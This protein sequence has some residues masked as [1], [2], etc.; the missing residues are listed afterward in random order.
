MENDLYKTTYKETLAKAIFIDKFAKEELEEKLLNS[1]TKANPGKNAF[2]KLVKEAF[3]KTPDMDA[4]KE[5]LLIAILKDNP[6]KDLFVEI[7]NI[8]Y[9]EKFVNAELEKNLLKAILKDKADMDALIELFQDAL[10]A[11]PDMDVLKVKL[12]NA[13][14]EGRLVQDVLEEKLLDAI[15]KDNPDKDAFVEII[16]AKF[17]DELVKAITGYG[18]KKNEIVKVYKI[19]KKHDTEEDRLVIEKLLYEKPLIVPP[20]LNPAVL[21][22]EAHFN[23]SDDDPIMILGP[24]GVGKSLFLYLA[25]KLFKKRHQYDTT[26]PIIV[27]ANCAHFSSG[28][29]SYSLA[30]SELFGHVEGAYTGAHK[31]KVGLVEIANGGLLIL[32]EVGELPFEVQAMLLT[33]IETGEYRRLGNEEV[34]TA[35]V[36]VVAATNRESALRDDFRYRFFPFYIPPLLERKYDILYYFHEIFPEITKNLSKSEVLLLLTHHWPGNVREIERIGRLINRE[37][38]I[39][40][41]VL[42]NSRNDKSVPP[43]ERIFHLDPRDTSFDPYFLESFVNDLKYWEVDVSFLE[44][45]LKQHRVSVNYEANQKAFKELSTRS[46]GY[47]SWF[48][49]YALK[50]CNDF[51]PFDDAYNGYLLFCDLFLQDPAKDNN[52][53][54][55]IK[56]QC[57]TSLFNTMGDY[58]DDK[59][60]YQKPLKVL[61]RQIMKYLNEFDSLEYDHIDNPWEFWRTL[62]QVAP[63]KDH[64]SAEFESE[65]VLSAISELKEVELLKFY[66][67]KQLGKTGGNIKAAAKLVG[68]KENTLRSRMTKLGMAF[69]KREL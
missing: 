16:N 23:V 12:L 18:F 25:R 47:F 36:K 38:W 24:T 50:F 60:S 33:F 63:D 37:N 2:K 21:H 14:F 39:N 44:K 52:I 17:I 69:R 68:L 29:G 65:E 30:R 1:I 9:E 66:Y 53:L 59:P 64:F 61:R 34:K 5:K 35:T 4:L 41:Q 57:T 20:G 48:D 28:D 3:K 55:T 46:N 45:L 19:V 31:D 8:A 27:E 43:T 49:G 32:E 7:V 51:E 67:R 58:Y 13:A 10:K 15:L 11:M 62:E 54:A 6:D 26:P 40:E 56:S 22:F 42:K